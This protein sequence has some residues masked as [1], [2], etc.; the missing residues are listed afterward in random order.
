MHIHEGILNVNMCY[1]G[2]KKNEICQCFYK[3]SMCATFI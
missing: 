2:F 3:N 1:L